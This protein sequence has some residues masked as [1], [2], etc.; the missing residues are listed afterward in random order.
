MKIKQISIL[1]QFHCTGA[2]CPS[3]C[4]RGWKIPIDDDAYEK[5]ITEKGFFGFV[6][7]CFLVKKEELTSFRCS[8]RHYRCPFWG[9]DRLCGLQKRHGTDY[10]PLVCVQ[11]PRQLSNFGSF[12][13]ET[14]YLAC[15]EAARLFIEQARAGIPFDFESHNG[16]VSYEENTT[17]DDIDFLHYLLK[18]RDE[19]ISMLRGGCGL[20]TA[21]LAYA[22]EAQNQCLAYGAENAGTQLGSSRSPLPSPLDYSPADNA[23]FAVDAA[24]MYT[25]FFKGF[26]HPSLKHSSPVL[27]KLCKLYIREFYTLTKS[28]PKAADKK[29]SGLMA[30]VYE[31]VP[32]FDALMTA[33]YEYYLQ[34]N[35]LDIFEDYSFYK[36]ML[37]GMAQAQMLQLFVALYCKG[38]RGKKK[39]PLSTEELS[40][41][42]AV[43]ERRA[44][45]IE[46]ALKDFTQFS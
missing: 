4:C 40:V 22:K 36:H 33:Y 23:P 32:D 28:N 20:N 35:F 31:H 1:K 25:L 8:K 38:R 44:P 7:R 15:A 13:E 41:I 37:C 5:Y 45:Q 21:L 19:L 30:N 14:L 9:L 43:Y 3:N 27:Y 16:D 46:D 10:M 6:L 34:K 18:S 39:H 42:M 17:N 24:G 29:L 26:Y 12:C 11:F 2:A